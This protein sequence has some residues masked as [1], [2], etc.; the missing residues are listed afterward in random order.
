VTT[1]TL[2][3]F[4]FS[5]L[6]FFIELFC[7][8]FTSS[9]VK[10]S[11]EKWGRT[12]LISDCRGKTVKKNELEDADDIPESSVPIRGHSYQRRNEKNEKRNK[13]QWTSKAAQH[14]DMKKVVP[15]WTRAGEETKPNTK[16]LCCQAMNLRRCQVFLC[17]C[18]ARNGSLAQLCC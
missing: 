4:L 6:A 14:Q 18:T 3:C 8:L 12:S 2:T 11:G 13:L 15:L 1:L 10:A 5:K 9:E 7:F 17:L 16:N